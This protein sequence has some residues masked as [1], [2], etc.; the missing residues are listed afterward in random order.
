MFSCVLRSDEVIRRVSLSLFLSISVLLWMFLVDCIMF[1]LWRNELWR[2]NM[3]AKML[4]VSLLL[5]L[6][7]IDE[8]EEKRENQNVCNKGV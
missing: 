2:V 3:D 7:C 5:V 1:V 8:V 4:F 6:Y